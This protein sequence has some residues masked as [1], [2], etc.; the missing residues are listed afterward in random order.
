MDESSR[1]MRSIAR[2]AP[3]FAAHVV[4]TANITLVVA[5][6]PLIEQSLDLGHAAFGLM[7]SAYYGGTLLLAL[8]AGWMVDRYGLRA[9]LIAAHAFLATGLVVLASAE[10]LVAGAAGLFLCGTG[11]AFIN[12][13]TARAVL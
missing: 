8:P 2:I 6:S 13:A 4:G 7:V 10:G 1:P 9:M 5:L 3:L 11:Y 12:P